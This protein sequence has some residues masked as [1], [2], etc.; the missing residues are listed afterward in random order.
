MLR[1]GL[2]LCCRINSFLQ[3]F[4]G[5]AVQSWTKNILPIFFA[6]ASLCLAQSRTFSISGKIS[7]LIDGEPLINVNV[8]IS[9]SVWGTSTDAKGYYLIKDIP[10]GNHQLV[11]SM[12]GYEPAQ[13]SITV[14]DKKEVRLDF[15]MKEKIY[16]MGEVKVVGEIPDDWY[17]NLEIFKSYFLGKSDFAD[18]CTIE[19]ETIINF[20]KND[21]ILSASAEKPLIIIN[22]ALG[23]KVTCYLLGFRFNSKADVCTYFS[24]SMFT[25]L[26]PEN[27]EQKNEWM[28]SRE[29]AY[30]GSLKHFLISLIRKDY[31]KQGFSIYQLNGYYETE[32]RDISTI[33]R[34]DSSN[35]NVYHLRFDNELTVRYSP[36]FWKS[37]KYS[38]LRMLVDTVTLDESGEAEEVLPFQVKKYWGTKGI[39][40]NLPKDYY[41]GRLNSP[42]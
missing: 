31:K 34:H 2:L 3:F 28:E 20:T 10:I 38:V 33:F 36:G 37:S 7:D 40:D 1:N 35:H 42:K 18:E 26:T 30:K 17:D 14:F 8:F 15:K 9:G 5:T 19:N 32:L 16:E 29:Q 39:A 41:T 23:Y 4:R 11:V 27:D 12:I 22:K 6:A 13:R 21:D 24:N 25:E